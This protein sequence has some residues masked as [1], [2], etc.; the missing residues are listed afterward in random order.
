MLDV[1][2]LAL[3]FFGLIFL[4]LAAQVQADPETGLA[5]MNFFIIYVA[6]RACLP[7]ARA[8]AARATQQRTFII[9]RRSERRAPSRC[10]SRSDGLSAQDGR[11][12][13]AGLSGA[14]GNI[15]YMGPGLALAT[16]GPAANVPVALI[17]C[18]DTLCVVRAR[19]VP[20]DASPARAR[21]HRGDGVRSGQTHRAASLHHRDRARRCVGGASF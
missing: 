10:R 17:F 1:I 5:W 18:F 14:Y 7:R 3:P 6:C 4:G 12:T 19:A 20:H 21:R 16:L 9:G 8:N 13:I 11:A 2:N 15:G